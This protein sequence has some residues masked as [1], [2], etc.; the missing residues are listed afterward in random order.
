VL[1][2]GGPQLNANWRGEGVGSCTDCRRY[3][4]EL[5][6]GR[7]SEADWAELQ[8]CIVRS[9]GHC[10]TMGTAS[11]MACVVEALGIAPPGNGAT[12]APDSRRLQIAE[13]AGRH[14]VELAERD[15]RPSQILTPRA[16]D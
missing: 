5:R 4:T 13:M 2:T 9:A 16:F 15:V 12:P 10:M 7:I 6:A 1:V 8:G 3:Q 11:T 14:A